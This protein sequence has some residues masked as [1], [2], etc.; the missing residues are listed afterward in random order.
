MALWTPAR[1][2]GISGIEELKAQFA[3]L[4]ARFGAPPA[5]V[6]FAA[7]QLGPVSGEWA[8]PERVQ[9]GR[10]ILYFHGG[11][12]ISGDPETH[13]AFS[14]KLAEIGEA[15]CFSVRY[16]LAPDYVF[17][18][19]VRDGIDAYRAL[20]A[21]GVEN[22]QVV[23]AGDGAGGGLAF[24]V[25]LA[26]RNAGLAMPAAIAAMSPWADLSL[27]G[28]SLLRNQKSDPVL[29]WELLFQCARHY[30]RKANPADAY[31]S[32]AFANLKDF[33]PVMV[34]AGSAEILRDDAS[35][36]GD[37]AAEA[38]TSMSVEIYDG[39]GHLFQCDS[40]SSEAKVSFSRLGQFIRS[41]TRIA[42]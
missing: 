2:V 28:W 3:Q 38:Q 5:E 27:S 29:D 14:G 33:P 19:P 31:A 35:K 36:L 32:P 7:A 13:R 11:G 16:R 42:L 15:D 40:R 17:P 6:A 37:R 9:P 24:A 23:L 8:K 22:R 12:F 20:I 26:I 18:A 21:A 30:L 4:F 1:K 10:T 25:A 34:H 39:L 41:K